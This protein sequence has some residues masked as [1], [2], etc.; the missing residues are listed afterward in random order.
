MKE[1]RYSHLLTF[2]REIVFKATKFYHII[3][4]APPSPRERVD[5]DVKKPTLK[6]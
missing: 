3:L 1:L 2:E 6:R 4:L 5:K